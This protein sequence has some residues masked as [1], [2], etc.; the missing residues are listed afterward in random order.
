MD[1]LQKGSRKEQQGARPEGVYIA[2][3]LF[4][5]FCSLEMIE[6]ARHL[7]SRGRSPRHGRRPGMSLNV[8][9]PYFAAT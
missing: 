7:A 2:L 1:F 8:S 6:G 9:E 4:A 5:P 3:L